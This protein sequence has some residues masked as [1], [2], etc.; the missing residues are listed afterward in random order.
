MLSEEIG[1][2]AYTAGV[3]DIANLTRAIAVAVAESGG[4]PNAHNTTA[5]DDSY[6]LWQI[7]MRGDLGPDRRSKLGISSD[8][9]LFDPAINA[10]AMF[11]ISGGGKNWGAWSTFGGLR[12]YAA[13]PRAEM[14]AVGLVTIG[15]SGLPQAA[16]AA[17]DQAREATQAVGD[18]VAQVRKAGAWLSDRNNMLRIA[19]VTV[20]G[21]LVVTGLVMTVGTG[22]LPLGKVGKIAGKIGG[23]LK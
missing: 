20:G 4:N 18:A 1:A 22:V 3:K 8:S 10:R 2:Y 12:F 9:Q 11:M 19:K 17:V 5:P 23:A 6:G 21:A 13:L 7:N 15:G 14:A 16:T